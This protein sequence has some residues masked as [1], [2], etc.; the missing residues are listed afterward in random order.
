MNRDNFIYMPPSAWGLDVW[1][2]KVLTVYLYIDNGKGFCDS[3]IK[4]IAEISGMSRTKAKE[5]TTFLVENGFI[6]V[7]NRFATY[8]THGHEGQLSNIVRIV[9]DE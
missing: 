9:K 2:F 5:C 8:E 1:A 6:T 3:S 7:E 4:E